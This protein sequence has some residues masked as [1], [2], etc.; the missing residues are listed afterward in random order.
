MAQAVDQDGPDQT[1]TSPQAN[2]QEEEPILLPH[3]ADTSKVTCQ[4]ATL[5]GYFWDLE[6][7][8]LS[9]GKNR[10]INLYPTRRGLRPSW[11]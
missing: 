7:D 6:H 8:S 4:G 11:G 3:P 2:Q 1:S 9:T 5:L 10:K